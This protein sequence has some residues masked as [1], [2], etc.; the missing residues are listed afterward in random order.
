MA[1]IV[2]ALNKE[3]TQWK[4]YHALNCCIVYPYTFHFFS[5][6]ILYIHLKYCFRV[7]INLY[8]KWIS[9][10]HK[11][12]ICK[13]SIF[14]KSLFLW[15]MITLNN[16]CRQYLSICL[17]LNEWHWLVKEKHQPNVLACFKLGH[18]KFT[19]KVIKTLHVQILWM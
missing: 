2:H 4:P 11:P 12:K 6:L 8:H 15:N 18:Y 5:R 14:H 17:Q 10:S 13:T 9:W 19:W 3:A 16:P 1:K 7:G